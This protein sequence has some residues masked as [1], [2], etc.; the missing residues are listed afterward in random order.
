M[1][2]VTVYFHRGS[3]RGQWDLVSRPAGPVPVVSC[4]ACGEEIALEGYVVARDGALDKTVSC[5][6]GCFDERAVLVGYEE[7]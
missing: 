4:P 3:R 2:G 5:P 6:R 7:D 1:K